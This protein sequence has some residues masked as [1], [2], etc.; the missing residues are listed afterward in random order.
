MT[1]FGREYGEGLYALCAEEKLDQAV[2]E[3][4]RAIGKAFK[5][6]EAFLH[7]LG[8][9]SMSKEERVRIVDETFKGQIHEYTLNFLKILVER[10]AIHAFSECAAA[11]QEIYFRDHQVA[12]AEVTTANPLNEEQKNKLRDKLKK[13]AG[14][15]IVIKEKIDPSVLG[16]VLLQMDGKRYDNTVRHRL[17]AIKQTM[18]EE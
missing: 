9:M 12:V 1:E 11:Y 17:A 14:K 13:I 3:E 15:E 5:E 18:T 2:L 4:M 7:L 6:N 16:G 10:G 8:N